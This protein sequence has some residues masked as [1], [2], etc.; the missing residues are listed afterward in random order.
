MPPFSLVCMAEIVGAHGVKGW[1]KLKVFGENPEGLAEG[2]PLCDAKRQRAFKLLSVR[3]HGNTYLAEIE[4]LGDRTAAEKLRGV[5]LFLPREA[6]PDI[7]QENTFYH[8]D[9]IGLAARYPDGRPLGKVIQVA[10]FGAGD[11]LEIKPQKGA[12]FYVPFTSAVVPKVDIAAKEV[13]VDPPPG[14]LD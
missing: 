7:G 12:S 1:V 3:A 2:P 13:V 11:L 14:L 6:L 5:K 9:L 10:N 4:G 8:V